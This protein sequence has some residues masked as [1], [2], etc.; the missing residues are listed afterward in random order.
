MKDLDTLVGNAT[1]NLLQKQVLLD[2]KGQYTKEPIVP[3]MIRKTKS[4]YNKKTSSAE[5]YTQFL[6]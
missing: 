2:T 1:I 4:K 5:Q 3:R 6:G